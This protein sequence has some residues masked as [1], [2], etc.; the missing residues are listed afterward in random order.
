MLT[1]FPS[2]RN[3]YIFLVFLYYLI[4]LYLDE[5]S[6]GEYNSCCMAAVS[7]NTLGTTLCPFDYT[8]FAVC[9]KVG[10]S[11]RVYQFNHNS[12]VTVISPT[13]RPKSVHN[14]CEIEVFYGDFV[15]SC[16]FLKFSVGV[17]AFVMGLSQN[18]SFFSSHYESLLRLAMFKIWNKSN[19]CKNI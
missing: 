2:E 18:S 3:S 6:E 14:R 17:R 8:A 11:L 7:Q 15:L 13:N 16:C 10:I 19:S 1:G 4:D 5:R 9:E 12:W